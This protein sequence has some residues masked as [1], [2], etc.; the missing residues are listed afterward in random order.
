[1]PG[2]GDV[3]INDARQAQGAG[4][5][6]LT[7]YSHIWFGARSAP[8]TTIRGFICSSIMLELFL[9]ETSWSAV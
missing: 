8:N 7:R 6:I 5:Y 3:R 1:M 2:Y 4:Q 9:P